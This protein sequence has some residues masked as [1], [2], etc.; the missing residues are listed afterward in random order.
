VD[1]LPTRLAY[2][3]V[4]PE[5]LETE[6]LL[7]R[8]WRDDDVEPLYEIYL[9]PEYLATMPALTLD[10]TRAQVEGLRRR[11]RDDGYCQWVACE[12]ESGRLIGRIGLL[13]HHDWPLADRPVPE[14]GWV[15]HRDF[16]NCGLATEGG[17]AGVEAWREHLPDEPRLYSF[18]T[19]AN[20]RSQAV[21][22]RLGFAWGGDGVRWHDHDMVWHYLDRS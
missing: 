6:R 17:R 1:T 5:E 12:R 15:L 21:M 3:A 7:L 19:P 14:V 10:E 20:A 2:A 4:I 16:W 22:R 11:W 18:T 9:Q 13:C 8:Q